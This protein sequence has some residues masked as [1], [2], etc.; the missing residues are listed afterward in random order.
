MRNILTLIVSILL[1]NNLFAQPFQIG[2]TTVTFIDTSRNNRSIAT[3]VYY[4]ADVAGDNE[5]ITIVTTDKFP[6]ISFGHGFVM[7]WNAYQ[8]IWDAVVQEGFIIA[9]PKT[10]G[11]LAPSHAEFGK[12]LAFVIS[13]L[14]T[15][16]QDT[17]SLFYN[18]V[19]TMN[20]VMGHSMG[21]GSAFLAAQFDPSIKTMATLAAA[22]TNPSAIQ[23]GASL[24]IP[25][26]IIAGGNDCV[27]PPSAN[28][29]PMYD[30][31]QS[32]CKTFMSINGGS[33]CQMAD[34][35]FLCSIGEA[36]CTPQPTIS[37]AEQHL[38]ISSYLL[39]WLKYELKGDCFSGAQFDSLITT[40][41]S[42]VFQKTC[43]L[44][45]TTTSIENTSALSLEVF[46]NPFHDELFIQNDQREKS[47]AM[48]EV[49]LMNGS[50]VFSQNFS[51]VK[52]NEKLKLNLKE[53]L[54]AGIYLLKVT[55]DGQH[56]F[57][58]II[59]Q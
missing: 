1:C 52:A 41:T 9:F 27:T 38:V 30:S 13:E 14:T 23:A 47:R 42:I 43:S 16:G 15:L 58:K 51:T 11:G 39:P 56:S 59:R 34:N 8:N 46:P 10:E 33:H 12:D 5:P 18:R 44:C 50:K 6:V 40:D 32:T 19:D 26:L 49:Y 22:E 17:S 31:L 21:G 36:T 48:I 37:R 3:E 7:T 53:N 4:P 55:M 20:C 35:N 29:V 57:R 45:T 25:S 24:S 28:Q 54:T 2:H